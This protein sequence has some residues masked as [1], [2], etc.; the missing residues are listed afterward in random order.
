MTRERERKKEGDKEL[1]KSREVELEHGR[2][3]KLA[4]VD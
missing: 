4:N 2:K 1:Q 3:G